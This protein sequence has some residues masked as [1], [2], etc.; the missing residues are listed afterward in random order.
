MDILERAIA[1]DPEAD[2]MRF[3][4]ASGNGPGSLRRH[5]RGAEKGHSTGDRVRGGLG[6]ERVQGENSGKLGPEV[7]IAPEEGR[8]TALELVRDEVQAEP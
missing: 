7:A 2:E 6:R 4:R 5:Y 8:R 1:Q 3:Q